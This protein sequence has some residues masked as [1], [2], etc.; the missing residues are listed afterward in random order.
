MAD[1]LEHL[2]RQAAQRV[3]AAL[4]R[5][6]AAVALHQLAFAERLRV[7]DDDFG[8]ASGKDALVDD[9]VIVGPRFVGEPESTDELDAVVLDAERHVVAT[10]L[11][12]DGGDVR[13]FELF[14]RRHGA[15]PRER[16]GGSVRNSRTA[17]NRD[18][19]CST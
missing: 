4:L 18:C 13:H 1:V 14:E 9:A 7:R 3:E 10:S 11:D 17:S 16:G 6:R 5:E 15:C 8:A 2:D 19:G 12:I